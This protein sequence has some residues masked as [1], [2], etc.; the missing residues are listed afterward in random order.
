MTFS[1]KISKNLPQL[2]QQRVNMCIVY[3]MSAEFSSTSYFVKKIIL[4]ESQKTCRRQYGHIYP[5]FCDGNCVTLFR[6]DIWNKKCEKN[7]FSTAKIGKNL[8]KNYKIRGPFKMFAKYVFKTSYFATIYKI[9]PCWKHFFCPKCK[10]R[11][12]L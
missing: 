12:S 9:R 2:T 10:I 7:S 3:T 11:P 5:L 4:Q 8:Q 1:P 6:M